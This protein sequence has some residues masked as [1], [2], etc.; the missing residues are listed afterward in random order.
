[1]TPI[2]TIALSADQAAELAPIVRAAAADKRNVIFCAVV[3]N[4]GTWNLQAVSVPSKIGAKIRKLLK[5]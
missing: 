1:M 5:S 2:V 3:P 4:L